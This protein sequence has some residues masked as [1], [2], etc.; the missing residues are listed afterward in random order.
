M[1]ASLTLGQYGGRVGTAEEANLGS[2]ASGSGGPIKPF[3]IMARASVARVSCDGDKVATLSRS[4][5]RVALLVP[6]ADSS[7]ILQTSRETCTERISGKLR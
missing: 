6:P 2:D 7:F 4:C 5:F 3:Q 1:R